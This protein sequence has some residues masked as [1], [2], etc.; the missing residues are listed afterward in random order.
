MRFQP[1]G[2][3]FTLSEDVTGGGRIRRIR[4]GGGEKRTEAI[5]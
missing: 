5:R 4:G 2:A 3:T 1:F